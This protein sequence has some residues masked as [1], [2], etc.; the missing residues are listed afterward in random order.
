M[1][2]VEPN[3]K[4]VEPNAKRHGK[5]WSQAKLMEKL[6]GSKAM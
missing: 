3:S 4:M 5:K 6:V 1:Q 2:M